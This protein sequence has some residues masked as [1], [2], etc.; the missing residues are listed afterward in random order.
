MPWNRYLR[1][2]WFSSLSQ[3]W[4][5][6]EHNT[7]HLSEPH[8]RSSYLHS[9]TPPVALL[10]YLQTQRPSASKTGRKSVLLT[11]FH[12]T[13]LRLCVPSKPLKAEMALP[14]L[15]P[16]SMTSL[17]FAFSAAFLRGFLAG[18]GVYAASGSAH[19]SGYTSLYGFFSPV[20]IVQ[21]R[22]DCVDRWESVVP[23]FR[24]V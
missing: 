18:G 12:P 24:R 16:S 11:S 6:L 23:S 20:R 17:I 7:H 1:C 8:T 4:V 9:T 14:P 13:L 10:K 3:I 22:S 5:S 19:I 2:F 21:H 15:V